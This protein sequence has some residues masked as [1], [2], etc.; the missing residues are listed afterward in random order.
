LS[1]INIPYLFTINNGEQPIA[2]A[3]LEV[4]AKNACNNQKA[5]F[6]AVMELLEEKYTCKNIV[7]SSPFY[8]GKLSQTNF[9][10]YQ[11]C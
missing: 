1:N 5:G 10:Q 4:P 3:I 2:S 9:Q 11:R 7:K 6:M 8:E